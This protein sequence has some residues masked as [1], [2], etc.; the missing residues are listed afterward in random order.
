MSWTVAPVGTWTLC[1]RA[2]K[3]WEWLTVSLLNLAT[4]GY[5]YKIDMNP[6]NSMGAFAIS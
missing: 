2:F 4:W 3:H 1:N 6:F 5:I